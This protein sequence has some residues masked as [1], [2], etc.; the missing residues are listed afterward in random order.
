[1]QLVCRVSSR[2]GF[3]KWITLQRIPD[4]LFYVP[5]IGS[6]MPSKIIPDFLFHVPLIGSGM[7]S[8]R[9]YYL[10]VYLLIE[11]YSE[12]PLIMLYGILIFVPMYMYT[13]QMLLLEC[14]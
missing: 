11:L 13:H 12:M 6:G 7:P 10:Q 2:L 3:W 1:M 9:L 14:H 5:L 8:I 4:L